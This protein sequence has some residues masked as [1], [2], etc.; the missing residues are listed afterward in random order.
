MGVHINTIKGMG[1]NVGKDVE[2]KKPLYA[3][4]GM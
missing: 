4:G 3:V 1:M 2:K